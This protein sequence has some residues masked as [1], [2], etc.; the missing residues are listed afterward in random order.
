M[1]SDTL[2]LEDV[3]R[4][5]DGF[6][7]RLNGIKANIKPFKMIIRDKDIYIKTDDIF[8]G[9]FTYPTSYHHIECVITRDK[10]SLLTDFRLYRGWTKK[11]QIDFICDISKICGCKELKLDTST[12]LHETIKKKYIIEC[13]SGQQFVTSIY[14]F[15]PV[16]P[17][18]IDKEKMTKYATNLLKILEKNDDAN[19]YYAYNWKYKYSPERIKSLI[20]FCKAII[21][22]KP[23]KIEKLYEINY[24]VLPAQIK[25]TKKISLFAKIFKDDTF[26]SYLASRNDVKFQ[27]PL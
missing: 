1:E 16:K 17:L 27:I 21:S 10:T 4:I 23:E 3:P 14:G 2:N 19:I 26:A 11:K 9:L 18:I 15:K 22:W 6:K 8:E 20:A 13:L 25:N 7:K 5:L 12:V 24:G